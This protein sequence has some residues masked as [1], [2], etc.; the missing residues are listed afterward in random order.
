MLADSAFAAASCW[1]ACQDV[2]LQNLASVQDDVFAAQPC[3]LLPGS[4][5]AVA[6]HIVF[7][8]PVVDFVGSVIVG[9]ET[10]I[11]LGIALHLGRTPGASVE[12][13]QNPYVT[14]GAHADFVQVTLFAS[15]VGVPGQV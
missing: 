14:S 6:S 8:P 9:L 15:F 3:C 7:V 11:G 1:P 10:L 2:D 5:A 13:A 4:V 12:P